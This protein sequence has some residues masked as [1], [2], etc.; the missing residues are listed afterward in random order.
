M[1]FV[2]IG[3]LDGVIGEVV[4]DLLVVDMEE[5]LRW[6]GYVYICIVFVW[7]IVYMGDVNDVVLLVFV[8]VFLF[9]V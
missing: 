6:Y 3:E 2:V 5:M 8:L 9:I 1:D 7:D 4:V